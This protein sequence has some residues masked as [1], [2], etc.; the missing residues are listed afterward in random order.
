[1]SWSRSAVSQQQVRKKMNLFCVLT[2]FSWFYKLPA[3]ARG[4]HTFLPTRAAQQSWAKL[5]SLVLGRVPFLRIHLSVDI[6][7]IICAVWPL[8]SNMNNRSNSGRRLTTD[9]IFHTST[10]VPYFTSSITPRQ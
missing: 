7:S 10:L 2:I 6:S 5:S 1:M 9:G 4:W 8:P 3:L